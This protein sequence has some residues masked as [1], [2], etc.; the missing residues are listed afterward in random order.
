MK[1]PWQPRKRTYHKRTSSAESEIKKLEFK[2][3]KLAHVELAEQFKS[4]D[5]ETKRELI[6]QILDIKLK[7][8]EPKSVEDAIYEE[9]LL[10]DPEYREAVKAARLAALQPQ[11]NLTDELDEHITSAAIAKIEENPEVLGE[12]VDDK[13]ASLVGK[14]KKD[15]PLGQF[16]TTVEQVEALKEAL[17]SGGEKKSWLSPEMAQTV[18]NFIT[19]MAPALLGRTPPEVQAD[20]KYATVVNDKP[21]ITRP[22]PKKL[23]PKESIEQ[24]PVAEQVA[25]PMT[26]KSAAEMPQP[27][28][29]EMSMWMQF[30]GEEPESAILRLMEF[31]EEGNEQAQQILDAMVGSDAIDMIAMLQSFKANERYREIV[32]RLES[33]VEWLQLAINYY[34]SVVENGQNN[35]SLV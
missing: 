26:Q 18:L 34:R 15:G 11:A 23:P 29:E 25:V 27:A 31:A 7:Y 4:A 19:T 1:M 16:L 28:D 8:K 30:L 22:E 6:G 24:K 20:R 32:E 5:P 12:A 2:Q 9:A 17:G 35:A 3:K 13:I 21:Q 10:N 33:K 14:R